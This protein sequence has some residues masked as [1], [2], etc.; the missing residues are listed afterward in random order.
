MDVEALLSS[1][2]LDELTYEAS[3]LVAWQVGA[4]K[5]ENDVAKFMYRH[6]PW[7]PQAS[8]QREPPPDRRPD[9]KYWHFVKKEMRT[10]L[11]TDDKRYRDLWKQIDALQKKSTTAL[12]GV[13]AAFLGSSIGAPATLIAGFVAVC[14]YAA[15][16][17]GKEAYC[18]YSGQG[19]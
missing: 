13:I 15:I 16:K 7:P 6:G 3:A 8:T 17:L 9:E 1:L 5:N 19:V 12:V 14:L 18:S 10:F 11:C 2:D 4:A